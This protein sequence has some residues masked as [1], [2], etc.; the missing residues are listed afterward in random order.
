MK[1]ARFTAAD[2]QMYWMSAKIPNDEFLLYAFDGEPKSI[3][4]ALAGVLERASRCP[5][6]MLR[7]GDGGPLT[8]PTWVRR[9]VGPDLVAVHGP[10]SGWDQ[11][12][13]AV[14]GLAR[15]QLDLRRAA[16]RLHIFSPVLNV[17]GST[18]SSAVA[19][20]Q[21]GHALGDGARS[22]A[23]AANV[24]GRN[25]QIPSVAHRPRGCLVERS[26]TAVRAQKQLQDDVAAGL[27]PPQAPSR[28]VLSTNTRPGV[29]RTI[30]TLMRRRTRLRGPTVTT[31]LLA[32]IAEALSGYLGDRG[33]D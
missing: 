14:S 20:L 13:D 12:L 5:E 24:F 25:A 23:L 33:E 16:W 8:F 9:E 31:A 19:V 10:A 29:D 17:P 6:L 2:A 21:M 27:V 4:D 3:D 1:G 28:P 15:D 7:V 30:R 18:G 22:S 32:V 11:C 26:I